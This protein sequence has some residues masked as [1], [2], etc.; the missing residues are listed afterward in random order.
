MYKIKRFSGK[1]SRKLDE[2]GIKPQDVKEIKDPSKIAEFASKHKIPIAAALALTAIGSGA[3]YSAYKRKKKI[4]NESEA[5]VNFS[6][7]NEIK[8]TKTQKKSRRNLGIL[9]GTGVGLS[10]A[11]LVSAENVS[12]RNKKDDKAYEKLQNRRK[13]I[14]NRWEAS[15]SKLDAAEE[16]VLNKLDEMADAKRVK[17]IRSVD[18]LRHNWNVA[19]ENL[20]NR[21]KARDV[22]M[23]EAN[24][25]SNAADDALIKSRKIYDRQISR[26]NRA[27]NKRLAIGLSAAAAVGLAT[28]MYVNDKLKKRYK[29]AN[30]RKAAKKES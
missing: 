17:N 10:G 8:E 26:I 19:M 21:L 30:E 1:F 11:A 27:A 2:L 5:E 4:N 15:R 29:K 3:V 25:L 23:E 9:S 6:D 7:K 20:D 16:A 28:G 12:Y 18:D 14:L 13:D 24:K 22:A